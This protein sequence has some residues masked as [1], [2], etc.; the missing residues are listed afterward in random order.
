MSRLSGFMILFVLWTASAGNSQEIGQVR[1]IY[2]D[3]MTS[4]TGR[5]LK[6][7][8][9][10]FRRII[11]MSLP[12]N[13]LFDPYTAKSYYFLGE[14]AFIRQD[15]ERA[16]D[17]YKTVAGLYYE[18]DIYPRDLYKLGRTLIISGRLNEGIAILEDYLSHY[19]GMDRLED[20]AYYWMARA[21]AGKGDYFKA[22]SF[23]K[24][25]LNNYMESDLTFESRNSISI[26]ENL[27]EKQVTNTFETNNILI[28]ITNNTE[29]VNFEMEKA[30][31]ERISRLLAI[32]QRLL[33]IKAA[34]V[35]ALSR[36]KEQNWTE[37]GFS[38]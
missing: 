31:L 21:Y 25:I 37:Q 3:G 8:G 7:A 35:D 36:L 19:G 10:N 34:R 20:H 4:F 30:I 38:K 22:I 26:L 13:S 17:F 6:K 27:N 28:N 1:K 15:Y 18:E 23:Y 2:L 24:F 32:K 11:G 29:N 12:R 14:I 9:D 5:D 16:V 33:E